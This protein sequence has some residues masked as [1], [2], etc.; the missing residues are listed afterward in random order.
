[1]LVE[2]IAMSPKV[3]KYAIHILRFPFSC[4]HAARN[5]SPMPFLSALLS[6]SATSRNPQDVPSV[7]SITR[8]PVP[9]KNQLKWAPVTDYTHTYPEVTTI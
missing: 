1:M 5:I 9:T 8:A 3:P 7:P 6:L 4:A 2:K